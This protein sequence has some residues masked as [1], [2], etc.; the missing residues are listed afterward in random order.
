MGNVS[1]PALQEELPL[2]VAVCAWCKPDTLGSSIGEVSHGICPRHLRRL[3]FEIR[4]IVIKRRRRSSLRT[5]GPERE[6]FLPL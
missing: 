1:A 4:G 5:L 6:A 3:H 2:Q